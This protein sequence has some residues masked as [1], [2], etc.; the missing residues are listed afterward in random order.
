[1]NHRQQYNLLHEAQTNLRLLIQ[2]QRQ[3][4]QIIQNNI[5][6]NNQN[7]QQNRNN[8]YSYNQRNNNNNTR[9]WNRNLNNPLFYIWPTNINRNTQGNNTNGLTEEQIQNST[10]TSTFENMEN[11]LEITEC[12]ISQHEFQSSTNVT[13]INVCNH[14][15]CQSSINTWLRTNRTCPVCRRNV[16]QLSQNQENNSTTN[17]NNRQNL[18]FTYFSASFNNRTS[19][20]DDEFFNSIF[21]NML[22]TNIV[23]DNQTSINNNNTTNQNDN[24]TN[25]NNTSLPNNFSYFS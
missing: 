8:Y 2:T 17:T 3:T 18:P 19:T 21:Q 22:N 1:M 6:N 15:F 11:P 16:I 13:R 7:E 24:I 5:Q 20:N 25:E 10:T 9:S 23:N 12:P 4:I 14:I